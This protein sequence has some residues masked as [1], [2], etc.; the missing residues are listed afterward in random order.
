MTQKI[1]R[2]PFGVRGIST[3]ALVLSACSSVGPRSETLDSSVSA[4]V[5]TDYTPSLASNVLGQYSGNVSGG[6][7]TASLIDGTSATKYYVNKQQLWLRYQMTRPTI[8]TLRRDV[9]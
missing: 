9:W 6:E 7:G 3:L 4:L 8:I 5:G 1:K 2:R